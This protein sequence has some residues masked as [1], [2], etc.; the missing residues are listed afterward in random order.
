[1]WLA[2]RT[3]RRPAGGISLAGQ[4]GVTRAQGGRARPSPS[5]GGSSRHGNGMISPERV[6]AALQALTTPVTLRDRAAVVLESLRAGCALTSAEAAV[7]T[8]LDGRS[9]TRYALVGGKSLPCRAAPRVSE[10]LV[11]ATLL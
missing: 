4:A 1:M 3:A 5:S 6:Q 9:P 2:P 7:L 10:G 11:R 8:L